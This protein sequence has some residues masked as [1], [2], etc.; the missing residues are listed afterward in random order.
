MKMVRLI[1][2]LTAL[3]T[4]AAFVGRAKFGAYGFYSG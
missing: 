1:P 4:L 2:V 3:L